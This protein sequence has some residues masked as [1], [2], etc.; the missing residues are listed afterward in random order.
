MDKQ[1]LEKNFEKVVNYVAANRYRR[2]LK[3]KGRDQQG[4]PVFKFSYSRCLDDPLPL[5]AKGKNIR[6]ILRI[7]VQSFGYMPFCLVKNIFH[8]FKKWSGLQLQRTSLR[9]QMF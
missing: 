2:C 7:T 9:L 4:M 6:I 8:L 3:L 5:P 1:I